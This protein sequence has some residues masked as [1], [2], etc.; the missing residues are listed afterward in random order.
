MEKAASV[1]GKELSPRGGFASSGEGVSKLLLHPTAEQNELAIL[2]G[3]E[4]ASPKH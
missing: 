2:Q 3:R 4:A 1:G